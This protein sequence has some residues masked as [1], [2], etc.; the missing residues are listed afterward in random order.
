MTDL[1]TRK[2]NRNALAGAALQSISAIAFIVAT[3]APAMAE[4]AVGSAGLDG[5]D[6]EIVVTA[7]RREETAQ[8]VPVALSVVSAD[9]LERSGNF[10]LGQVQQ[11]VPSLQVQGSNPRNTSVNIRGLGANSSAAIDGLEYGVGF[12]VDG[13]Y[14]GSPGQSQFDLIDLAQIEVLRGSR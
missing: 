10:T 12:Y 8:D 11:L 4:T 1:R 3:Q 7:R 14:Y 9:T 2:K 6:G 5:A 13:V